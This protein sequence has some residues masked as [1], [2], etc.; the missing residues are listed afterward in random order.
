MQP[1]ERGLLELFERPQ[2]YIIPL[3]Q[4][5]YVWTQER[6]WAPL[7][8]DIRERADEELDQRRR[9]RVKPH[10]LGAVVLG[11]VRTF[12][13]DL[14]AFD[15]I[16]GQQRLTTFQLFLAAFRDTA[17]HLGIDSVKRELARVTANDGTL[18]HEHEQYKV[19]PTQFDQPGFQQAMAVKDGDVAADTERAQQQFEFVPNT[20]AAHSYFYGEL[21]RWL[22]GDEPER[23]ADAL[24]TA[25]SRY[26][27]VVTIELEEDD[28]PQVIFETLNAR[29][30]PLEPADLV[31]N[32]IFSDASRRDEP[33]EQLFN[34]YWAQFD[35]D[36][37]LWRTTESR[38]RTSRP[39]LA[40]FLMA[41]LSVK[42]GEEVNDS[43]I[44]DAFKRWWGSR[45]SN[46]TAESGLQELLRYAGA[47]RDLIT[48]SPDTRLGVFYRRLKIMDISTLTPLLLYLLTDARLP[49]GELNGII[50][51]LE[52][53]VVRRFALGMGSKNYN[54]HF[55]RLLL[56]L[57][58]LPEGTDL[59][60]YILNHLSK[61]TGESVRW[62]GDEEWR[63]SLLT[64]PVYKKLRPRGVAMLLE[65]ID[66]KRT[67]GKQEQL[68]I[69]GPLSVEHVLPQR[70][71]KHWP[72]PEAS[73]EILDPV[74]WRN[75]L[76][77]S[78]G[79]LTLTTQKLNSALSN[80]P[81]ENK[82]TELAG[83]SRLRLNTLFQTQTTWDEEI[84]QQ[85]SA[86]LAADLIDIW[87]GPQGQAGADQDPYVTE[88]EA[89]A[90]PLATLSLLAEDLRANPIPGFALS[91]RSTEE[92][93]RLNSR[94]WNRHVRYTAE[95]VEDDS[96]WTQ[97]KVAL[98]EA[99]PDDALLKPLVQST[100]TR[101]ALSFQQTFRSERA[102]T[103]P[104]ELAVW[105]PDDRSAATLRLA[106]DRLHAMTVADLERAQAQLKE[107]Q[108]GGEALDRL[109]GVLQPCL[110][111]GYYFMLSDFGTER[112]YRRLAS[113]QWSNLVH[114]EL[115][116]DRGQLSLQ[117]DDELAAG[118]VKDRLQGQ[119][120]AIVQASKDAFPSTEVRVIRYP[121]GSQRI[122]I[123]WPQDLGDEATCKFV[124]TFIA[125]TAPLVEQAV[126]GE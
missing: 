119:W 30:E 124:N 63:A 8:D 12:G 31:R 61:G 79:N 27:K 121:S 53:Y 78:I 64:A 83:Q 77:H 107:R 14:P 102:E 66:M 36:G 4:R 29:G 114:Y 54:L 38:G 125:S 50:D 25:L 81:Y 1:H 13:R 69:A 40:W 112:K 55:L 9:E 109:I 113:A 94:D 44:F 122:F 57:R 95:L 49:S 126:S 34:R 110:P 98:S 111:A 23:R 117:L 15:V 20:L 96:G 59:R 91:R 26:L 46:E 52:S 18:T 43:G 56:E 33:V 19:W 103:S 108:P 22:S 105:L 47:Y 87:H 88:V 10:F 115:G 5:R 101:L 3:Y 82:R 6:Q 41:F 51:D 7:W 2:R 116:Y 99:F 74:A 80:G 71:Q 37:S 11:K 73:E 100:L 86:E 123:P 76:L 24:Y 32:H 42:L 45:D 92:F 97:F 84:I 106:L 39:Q 68:M 104:S 89:S 60:T 62:P 48:S 16:D 72:A 75:T 21:Q 35:A 120:E 28:D 65:A 17:R 67:T 58:Q 85:R 90:D 70:W 93:L 118:A